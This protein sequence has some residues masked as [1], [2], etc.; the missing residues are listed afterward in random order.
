MA[1]SCC[2]GW[3]CVSTTSDCVIHSFYEMIYRSLFLPVFML[4]ILLFCNGSVYH[5][6]QA[7]N[8][9]IIYQESV[10]RNGDI[11]FQRGRN[12]ASTFVVS[13]DSGSV[14]SHVGIICKS[15]NH[16]FVIHILP[17][18]NESK[19]GLVRREPLGDFLSPERT[20]GFAL[21]RLSDNKGTI[22]SRA[23]DVATSFFKKRI[24]Y[25]YDMDYKNHGKL[26]CTEL[27]W[28]AYRMAHIDL[29]DGKY[30][31]VAFPFYKGKYI[32]ISTLLKSRLLEKVSINPV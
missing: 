23:V 28:W 3:F 24:H 31:S 32:L 26:Y 13:V 4:T 30:E 5:Q 19:E 8:K 7:G 27:V 1:G 29:I 20:S 25:D 17:E 9:K 22:P 6:D 10:F 14:Y 15:K 2:K 12:V 11:I 18:S 21:Y 16:I